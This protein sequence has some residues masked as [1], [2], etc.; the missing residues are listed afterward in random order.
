MSTAD[1]RWGRKRGKTLGPPDQSQQ[2]PNVSTARNLGVVVGAD[3]MS[4][5][6]CQEAAKRAPMAS[7]QVEQ[8]LHQGT[9]TDAPQDAVKRSADDLSSVEEGDISLE[10][11]SGG[12][13]G[14]A[15]R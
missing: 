1:Q 7:H 5:L 9:R 12:R 13:G 14:R 3:F 8:Q 15:K 11:A 10:C 4:E 6:R 2:I